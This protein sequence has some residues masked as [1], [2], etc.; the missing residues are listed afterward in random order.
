MPCGVGD[1]T[2]E[3]AKRLANLGH[4]VEI[5]TSKRASAD[6]PH[7]KIRIHPIMPGWS[8]LLGGRLLKRILS[9][10]PD[11]VHLQYPTKAYGQGFA[12]SLLGM[13]LKARKVPA[14]YI[15]TLHE[16]AHAHP[17]RKAAIMPLLSEATMVI[18]PST[19]ERNALHKR[20][21]TLKKIPSRV[22][23]IGAV[24][25]ENYETLL[26]ELKENRDNLIQKW[27]IPKDGI[28]VNYGFLHRH[29]GFEILLKAFEVILSSGYE[30]ELWHVGAFDPHR[31]SYDRF[32]EF[33]SS[34][35]GLKDKVKFKGFLPL[36]EAAEIFSIARIGVF[37][38]ADGYSDRRSSM[39]TFGHF[40][41][42]MITTRS[43]AGEVNERIK[44]FVTLV[45]PKNEAMLV[46]K[47]E[48]IIA[49][50]ALYQ[51]AREKASGFKNL[52]DWDKIAKLNEQVYI[53]LLKDTP[54]GL[55]EKIH[56][57]SEII[58]EYFY[59]REK[60]EDRDS[61]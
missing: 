25:P 37:P 14:P 57:E 10:D 6:S 16:F 18:F 35:G 34:Q 26:A 30:C 9:L 38:F 44:N 52:Y 36:D 49:N 19:Q 56:R 2:R 28:I 13:Q 21:E 20:F 27:R 59:D 42:P 31:R 43:S 32:I 33:I 23:P 45:E 8:S 3:L 39:I 17:L 12:P 60:G 50:D 40:N 22:I 5:I 47:M 1:N 7:E 48:E 54:I 55:P 61:E 4:E 58:A 46:E 15:V 41:A 53:D 11:I 29:K 51:H 24:L